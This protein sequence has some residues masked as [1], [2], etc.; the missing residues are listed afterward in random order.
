MPVIILAWSE[1][2]KTATLAVPEVRGDIFSQERG[3]IQGRPPSRTGRTV[4]AQPVPVSRDQAMSLAATLACGLS[5]RKGLTVPV[6]QN[7]RRL[8]R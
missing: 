4:P 6:S 2:R 1:T 5:G 7:M 8:S 3:A